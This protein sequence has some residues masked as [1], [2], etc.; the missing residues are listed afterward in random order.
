[1]QLGLCGAAAQYL[2][3]KS[4]WP[5]MSRWTNDVISGAGFTGTVPLLTAMKAHEIA[6]PRFISSLRTI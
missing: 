5:S 3:H 6:F 2:W 1:M 4:E